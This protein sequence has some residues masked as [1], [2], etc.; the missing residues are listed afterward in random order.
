MSSSDASVPTAAAC[1]VEHFVCI[2]PGPILEPLTPA[3]SGGALLETAF[4]PT[5][6]A[7]F[8]APSAADP[9]SA[10]L[11]AFC[12][13]G[14]LYVR[15][16]V[17]SPRFACFILT[18]KDGTRLYG[19]CLTVYE[20][21][22]GST[23]VVHTE[24]GGGSDDAVSAATPAPTS[25]IDELVGSGGGAPTAFA[26]RCLCLL[27]RAHYPLA[28][29]A[30][31]SAVQQMAQRSALSGSPP[32]ALPLEASLTHLVLNVPRPV[33]GGP[34]VRFSLGNGSA[35][36]HVS[37]APPTQLPSTDYSVCELLG[38]LQPHA[39]VRLFHAALLELQSNAARAFSSQTRP[40]H[41][42][43]PLAQP[44]SSRALQAC[45]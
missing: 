23:K 19:H 36:L 3:A 14:A 2:G 15:L 11:P 39:V 26:P 22:S 4:A 28:F 35:A 40:A 12:L 21:I 1:L 25:T 6:L 41:S 34:T 13:P 10:A 38:R 24:A 20:R 43:S 30:S 17:P 18:Q 45:C 27:S 33:P 7:V 16:D 32:L 9:P 42:P 5:V 29:K 31:L 8:S 37:C 44:A